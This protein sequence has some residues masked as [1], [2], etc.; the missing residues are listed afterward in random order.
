MCSRYLL[1]LF[2]SSNMNLF[3]RCPWRS[4]MR[5]Q[6]NYFKGFHLLSVWSIHWV[7][8][9]RFVRNISLFFSIFYFLVE[10]G[11]PWQLD[12]FLYWLEKKIYTVYIIVPNVGYHPLAPQYEASLQT[13]LRVLG[14]WNPKSASIQGVTITHL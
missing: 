14:K 9:G 8:F 6:H 12:F 13:W 10:F 2:R 11:S 7:R 5:C 3:V 4:R 1:L